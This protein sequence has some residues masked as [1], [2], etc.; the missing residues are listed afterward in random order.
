MKILVATLLALAPLAALSTPLHYATLE[1]SVAANG[2]AT[3]VKVLESSLS[4]DALAALVQ[5]AVERGYSPEIREGRAVA[6]TVIYSVEV[7]LERKSAKRAM[8]LDPSS[9]ARAMPVRSCSYCPDERSSQPAG[10]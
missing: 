9:P 3:D 4:Q 5:D 6:S 10:F 7:S 8:S 1:V 2:R